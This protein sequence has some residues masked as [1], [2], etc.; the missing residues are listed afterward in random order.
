MGKLSNRIR[1]L[2]ARQ[3]KQRG[4]VVW[5]DPDNS[6]TKL[7]QNL[8]LAET[9]VLIYTDGFFRLRHEIEPHL[10]FVTA[11]GKPKDDCG[12]PPNVVV[13]VPMER[14]QTAHALIEVESSGV[15]VEPGAEVLE[16]NSRLRVQAET[17][18]LEVAPEKAAHLARQVDEGLLTLEDLDNIAD[19]VGSIG[20]GALKLVFGAASPLE[21]IIAFASNSNKDVKITAKN[22]LG[23]LRLLVRSELGLDFGEAV[24]CSPTNLTPAWLWMPPAARLWNCILASG[25]ERAARL[26]MDT[27]ARR[28]ASWNWAETWNSLSHAATRASK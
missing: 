17:L 27:F 6:Y 24:I 8:G 16:R 26:R 12:V 19:E 23:E 10:D 11:D 13:Y 18:F 15:I 28:P 20:S 3:V 5:Y 1:E 2:L 7:A 21:L 22:S 9:T 14:D 25:L 4:I